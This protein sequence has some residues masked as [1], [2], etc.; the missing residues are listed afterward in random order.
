MD[1]K[2]DERIFQELNPSQPN[3]AIVAEATELFSDLQ[4]F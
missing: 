4:L 3:I 1:Q 2:T